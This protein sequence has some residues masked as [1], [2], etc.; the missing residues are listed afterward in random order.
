MDMA[1]P[2]RIEG[3]GLWYHVM[4]RGNGGQH[5]FRDEKDCESFLTRLGTVALGFHVEIHAYALMGN[6]LHLFVR[7]REA[8]LGRFM[9]RLLSGYTQWFNFRHTTCGHVFQGRYKALL[10]DKNAYGAEVSRYIH[11]N[12]AR[13]GGT[14]RQALAQRQAALRDCRWSSYRAMIGIA[15]AEEWLITK[16]TL[17]RWGTGVREQ[18]KNYATFVEQGL[19]ENV[20]D[21]AE[22]ARAQSI[23]GHD[24]FMDRVRRLLHNRGGGDRESAVARRQLTAE[25]VDAVVKRVARAYK[26]HPDDVRKARMGMGGNEARKV[27]MWLA[28]E[29]CGAVATVR[30]I[31]KAMG[32]VSGSAVVAAHR[33]IRQRIARDKR[34]RR[35]VAG[36]A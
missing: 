14:S 17:A 20:R 16:D 26:V 28:R 34:L 24:R 11:L 7:T 4:C 3:T 18:Q 2:L 9:Q 6:H 23:L 33:R 35:I 10:V 8:N 36:L 15:T 12:P 32:G 21:P 27:A 19:I 31:G 30:E 29:R 1:R 5:V 25:S 22:E 13:V